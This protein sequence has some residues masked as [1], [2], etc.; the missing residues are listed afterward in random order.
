VDNWNE[1]AAANN[2]G[3]CDLMTRCHGGHGEFAPDA[4]TSAVRTPPLYPDAV[5]L[6]PSLEAVD[7]LDRID[8]SEGCTIKDS[9]STLN[10]ADDGFRVLFD[11]EWIVA[12]SGSSS[13]GADWTQISRPEDLARWEIAWAQ[14]ESQGSLFLPTLLDDQSVAV[15]A[16]VLD[17]QVS[18]GA[19]L[20][21]SSD[22]VGLS[23]V[24]SRS[25]SESET[26]SG[27]IECAQARFPN[28]PL[29]GYES[30]EQLDHALDHGFRPAGSL[31]I[32]IAD[33]QVHDQDDRREQGKQELRSVG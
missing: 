13:T 27:L 1:I 14:G 32:W 6:V 16:R 29:V 17:G 11:A 12:S 22:S 5:T 9:F 10:L 2:A 33:G 8:V 21:R 30:G 4:W 26:W 19:I 7:L 18:S 20:Y 25:G 24:F 3:W 23:N 31:R 15:V 28:I